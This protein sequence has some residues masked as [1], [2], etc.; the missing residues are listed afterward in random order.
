MPKA[1]R[2]GLKLLN[3]ANEFKNESI[4]DNGG[5]LFCSACGHVING[6]TRFLVK[7][8]VDTSKH[9]KNLALH[10]KQTTLKTSKK[11]EFPAELC[12]VCSIFSS[13]YNSVK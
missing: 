9:Q 3:L 10:M 2:T 11:R 12:E 7:Q 5:S 13:N 1:V 8:H 4:E 6:S